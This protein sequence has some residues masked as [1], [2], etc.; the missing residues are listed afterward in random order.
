MITLGNNF[1][2]GFCVFS[3]TAARRQ[4][5][6][7][8]LKMAFFNNFPDRL[9]FPQVCIKKISMVKVFHH[10]ILEK[11]KKNKLIGVVD[12]KI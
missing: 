3:I 9:Y 6:S 7:Q 11:I 2:H 1:D 10:S 4:N 12:S 5:S 8:C